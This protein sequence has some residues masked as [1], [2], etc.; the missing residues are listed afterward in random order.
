[1]SDKMKKK[2]RLIGGTYQGFSWGRQK[3]VFERGAFCAEDYHGDTT[4]LRSYAPA[5]EIE[6]VGNIHD[7]P[8]LLEGGADNGTTQ[9]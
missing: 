9:T 6:V 1:M 4:P 5:V 7:N 8:E 2:V 3:V